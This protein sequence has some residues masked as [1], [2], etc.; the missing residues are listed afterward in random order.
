MDIDIG[1]IKLTHE[2]Y[3]LGIDVSVDDEHIIICQYWGADDIGDRVILP[4]SNAYELV[5]LLID[6]IKVAEKYEPNEENENE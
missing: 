1:T 5:K 6:A 2:K 3:A 4:S